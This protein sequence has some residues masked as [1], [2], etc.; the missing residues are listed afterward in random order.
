MYL[1][2][3]G[4]KLFKDCEFAYWNSYINNTE[5]PGPDDRLGSVYG[6]VVGALFEDFYNLGLWR[7]DQPQGALS[8]RVDATV[9]KVLKQETTPTKY[10]RG[11]VLKWK[12][13]GPDKSP[14]AMYADVNELV[15]DVRDTIGRGFR[16]IRQERL[17]GPMAKAEV[18]LD[19]DIDGHR[20]AGR[21]DLIIRRT[22]PYRDL[23]LLDGKGSKYRE[24][25]VDVLQLRWYEMLFRRKT[26]V[27]PDK[28]GFLFWR[29]E[30]HEAM[31]W[32]EPSAHETEKLLERVLSDMRKIERLKAEA[33]L[34]NFVEARKV[35]LPKVEDPL[36]G[37]AAE[38]S[39]RFCSYATEGICPQGAAFRTLKGWK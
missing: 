9:A 33:P 24:A 36:A 5:S 28:L 22:S 20:V 14:K 12:G 19:S 13:S 26:G 37:A 23:V 38:Q 39:C 1:S 3:S 32:H 18:Q 11:G 17:L 29:F 8:E 16:I 10:R 27:A 31:D 25:Y 15:S 35:F 6:S 7:L 21:A 2:Y 34:R 4:W 30:P